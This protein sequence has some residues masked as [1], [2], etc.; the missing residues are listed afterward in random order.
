MRTAGITWQS[1]KDLLRLGYD[2]PLIS[3]L[4]PTSIATMAQPALAW[5]GN[6]WTWAPQLRWEHRFVFDNDRQA[7]FE[8]PGYTI[9]RHTPL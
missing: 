1:E 5:S 7:A 9:P 8:L 3:P 6:L 4:S 2:S